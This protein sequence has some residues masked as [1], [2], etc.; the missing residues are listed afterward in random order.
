MSR[1]RERRR[2]MKDQATITRE[3]FVKRLTILCLK[4]G[5][6][7][8]PKDDADR[9][10]LLKSAALTFNPS[11]AYSEKEVNQVLE[12]WI[13]GIGQHGKMDSGTV[14]RY[15]VDAG[16]LEREK[17]G[18]SYWVSSGRAGR[19]EAEVNQVDPMGEIAR[20]RQ[21]IEARKRAFME[22]RK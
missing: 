12:A 3:H 16:Y 17:D 13:D 4:S 7:G 6:S 14:R 15:L 11:G 19:F 21:E 18:S 22:K 1:V 9:H 2:P 20:A 5:L 10:I 8:F